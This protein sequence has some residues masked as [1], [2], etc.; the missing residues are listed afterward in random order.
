MVGKYVCSGA[1][2]TS[3]VNALNRSEP[4]TTSFPG[5]AVTVIFLISTQNLENLLYPS[6]E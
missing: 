3:V 1:Q 5:R 4:S 6:H 2:G